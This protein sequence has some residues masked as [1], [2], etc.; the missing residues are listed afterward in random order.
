MSS[1]SSTSRKTSMHAARAEGGVTSLT[2]LWRV[3]A[4]RYECVGT[5]LKTCSLNSWAVGIDVSSASRRC[6]GIEDSAMALDL[7][8]RSRSTVRSEIL[9]RCHQYP[10]A[11]CE[12]FRH[13]AI[14]TDRP[15]SQHSVKPSAAASTK[16]S[17]SSSVKSIPRCCP[18]EV[19]NAG[20][21]CRM[22][23][24]TGA[25]SLNGPTSVPRR[26]ASSAVASAASRRM[27]CARGRKVCPSSVSD[28][29]RVD[30]W[31]SRVP[32]PRSKSAS[33]SLA[34]DLADRAAWR[35]R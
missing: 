12:A 11:C 34:T 14:V 8:Q 10:A 33:R 13:Q 29:F 30:R 2:M 21:R 17:S 9:G 23:K 27:R 25:E 6:G 3:E 26:S 20:P 19:P 5:R 15:M 24:L 18:Q 32:R 1:G 31:I 22:P 4:K 28:S 16:R 7:R 35:P